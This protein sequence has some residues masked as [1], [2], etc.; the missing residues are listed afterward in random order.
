[1][2]KKNLN[3]A[4]KAEHQIKRIVMVIMMEAHNT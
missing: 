2:Q 4:Q 3:I 1:M